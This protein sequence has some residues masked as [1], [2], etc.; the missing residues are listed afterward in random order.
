LNEDGEQLSENQNE[1]N[2]EEL[3][4]KTIKLI[5]LINYQPGSI[6]SRTIIDKEAGTVTLFAFDKGQ[7]LSEHK[8]PYDAM[9]YALDGEADITISGNPLRVKMG[10]MVIMPANEPHALKAI[11]KFMM[12]LIMI[13]S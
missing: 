6:V 4:A 12:L 1:I 9:V 11:K 13:R 8:A 10:E 5:S 2:Y 3:I 7:G